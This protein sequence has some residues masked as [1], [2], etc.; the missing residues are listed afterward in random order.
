MYY[1]QCGVPVCEEIKQGIEGAAKALGWTL[2]IITH[3]DTPETV[4][5]AWQAVVDSNPDLVLASG[6]PREFFEDQLAVLEKRN[7]PVVV[8]SLP[9][10]Y[11]PGNGLDANLL[12][13]DDYYFYGVLMADYIVSES[14]GN[15]DTIFFGLPLFPVLQLVSQ[16]FETEYKRA[17]PSCKLKIVPIDIMDLING[18]VPQVVISELQVNPNANWIP[19]AFGGMLFGV[20]E[21]L[22]AVDLASR[23]SS[24]SQAGGPLNFNF[25]E[26]GAVQVAEVGLASEYLGWRAIDVG[27]RILS[28][29]DIGQPKSNQF[30]NIPGHPD[31]LAAG[32][33]LQILEKGT[34]NNPNQL[35]PG[36]TD[37]QNRFKKL[38]GVK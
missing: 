16:G 35:W 14:N 20:P 25:I 24:I 26:N 4:Q 32:L 18:K 19:F 11:R 23:V 38:W 28:G 27:A 21:A 8:W 10:P 12:S 15:A 34:L 1:I 2:N 3:K 29:Q 7:V 6:N 33:P 31:V 9:E 37:F 13:G 17:C 30:V 5:Q 36:V 22:D